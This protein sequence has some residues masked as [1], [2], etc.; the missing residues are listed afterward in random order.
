VG[1]AAD[2]AAPR[3]LKVAESIHLYSFRRATSRRTWEPSENGQGVQ[4]ADEMAPEA[5]IFLGSDRIVACFRNGLQDAEFSR[6]VEPSR[7]VSST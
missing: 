1:T 5:S 7:A 6:L 2:E 4:S 3:L